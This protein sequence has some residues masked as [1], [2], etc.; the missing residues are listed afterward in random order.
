M[1]KAK[2]AAFDRQIEA[3]LRPNA[4]PSDFTD[5]GDSETPDFE[6]CLDDTDGTKQRMREADEHDV[7]AFDKHLGAETQLSSGDSIL[8][9]T[10]RIR[11]AMP[12]VIQLEKQVPIPCSTPVSAKSNFQ[13]AMF[14]SMLPT[15]L[16]RACS[17]VDD[18]GRHHLLL[19][20]LVDHVK[21]DTAVLMDNG[22][23]VLNGNRRRKLTTKGR[24]L[25]VK[26]KD[27]STS[28]EA[29]N[30]LKEMNPVEVAECAVG[31]KLVS[32]P[33]FAWWVPFN[34]R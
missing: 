8:R 6:T 17:Q 5:D 24:K 2:C 13:M 1:E 15:L 18:K 23:V 20:F 7:N 28:W 12:M 9:G 30:N 25:C 19:E 21:D 16:L 34:L 11:R 29:L 22:C 3:K 10:L 32:E 33:A 4:K 14:E 31:A 27:G 26:W